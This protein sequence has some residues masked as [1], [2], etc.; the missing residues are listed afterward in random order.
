MNEIG[1]FDTFPSS[2]SNQFNGAWSVY[3]YFASGSI[4]ISDIERGLFVVKKNAILSNDGF[5][6]LNISMHPNPSN[7]LVNI[8]LDIPIEKIEVFNVLGVKVMSMTNIN[9]NEVQFNVN[10]LASGMYIVLVNDSFSKKL[11][12]E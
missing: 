2:N 7:G 1:F 9:S 5:T 3:P 10:E 12:V 8:N 11:I 4:I 6:N